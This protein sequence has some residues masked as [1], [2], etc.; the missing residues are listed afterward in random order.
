MNIFKRFAIAT[1]YVTILPIAPASFYKVAG[2]EDQD[3]DIVLSGLSKYLPAVGLLIG[4][5]LALLATACLILRINS[6]ISAVL[7]TVTWLWLTGALHMD[8]L[9][10]TADGVFSHRNRER[11]LE[12]MQDSRVG[13]FGALTGFCTVLL[14][15]AALHSLKGVA[16]P[17]ILLLAPVWGRWAEFFAIGRFQ[18]AKPEG[19]GKIWHDST[20][21]PFD[22]I[23]AT[24]APLA[25]TGILT[26][27][28]FEFAGLYAVVALLTGMFVSYYLNF[29]LGGHTGDTYGAVVELTETISMVV[30]VFISSLLTQ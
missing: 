29:R 9:M 19:K 20:K 22:L 23:P 15:V 5:I 4:F 14:K 1:A 24:I 18:Y 13:N 30:C 6:L 7:L 16:L 10:D 28:G 17:I 11:M 27:L 21:Y 26:Y 12:I 25:V 8:G 2:K 3:F